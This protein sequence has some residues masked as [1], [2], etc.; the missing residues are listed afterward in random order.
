MTALRFVL[1][2]LRHYRRIHV[3]VALGVAVSTAVLAGAL[4]VGDS[5]RGSLRDLTL[6]RLG[7]IDSALVG[8][9]LFRAALAEDLAA[10]GEFQRHFSVAVPA[11]LTMGSAQ[12]GSGDELRRATSVSIVGV[13]PQFWSLG[14]G[15]PGQPFADGEVAITVELARELGVNV[16]Q[17]VLLR[18]PT[19]SAIPSDSPLGE[20]SNTSLSRQLRVAAVLPSVGLARFALSPSQHSP[21][22]AFVTIETLQDLLD[23]PGKANVILAATE[24]DQTASGEEA[25][26]ALQSVLRPRLEDY[27]LRVETVSTPTQY[28]Q[29]TSD[30]LVLPNEVVDAAQRAFRDGDLQPVVTYLANTIAI[31]DGA[32]LRKIPYSTITGVDSLPGIGPLLDEASNPIQLGE[33]EIVLNR[34]AADD[35]NAQIGDTITVTYYEPESSHGQLREHAPPPR[36]KL[37]SIVELKTPGGEPMPAADPKLTPEMPGV[38]DQASI[39]DWDLPFELVETIRRQDEDYWDEYRTTPKAF[40]PFETAKRL[41]A[42][43]WGTISLLRIATG[44]TASAAAIEERLLGELDPASLGLTFQ[45]V[46]AQGLAAASGTTPFD[47]LFLGFSFFLMASAVMLIALLFQLGVEQRAKELGTLAAVG[48]DRRRIGRLLGREGLL[49][50][51]LGATV[52]VAAGIVYAWLMIKGLTTWWVSAIGTPFLELHATPRSILLGWIIGVLVS[53]LAILWSIR[54]LARRSVNRLLAGVSSDLPVVASRSARRFSLW[55]VARGVLVLLA[56]GN[57]LFL[58]FGP[59]VRSETDA[60]LFFALGAVVLLLILGEIHQRLRTANASRLKQRG[61]SLNTL[62]ALNIARNAGRSTLT[63]GLVSAASFLILGISAFRLESTDKGTGGFELMATSDRPIHFDLNT[64]QGRLEL[65]FTDA[66]NDELEAWRVYSFRVAAGEDASCLN[67]YRPAQPRVLGVP[68]A[69]FEHTGFEFMDDRGGTDELD[70]E[71][72][73]PQSSPWGRLR[74]DLGGDDSGRSVVP[75][76][77]DAS[78]AAYSLHLKGLGSRLTIRDADNRPVT[79]E[80]VGLLKNSVLQGN[81][82]VSE[83]NFLRLFPDTGGY[84]FFLIDRRDAEIAGPLRGADTGERSSPAIDRVVRLLESAL[85]EDGFDVVDARQQ[86]A[87]FLAVQN[88]YLSTFQSLGALGLLLGTVGLAIVQLR[89]VLERRGELALMRAAGFRSGRLL[90]MVMLENVLLLLGGLIVGGIAAAIALVPQWLP[91][92]A[93]V[94]WHTLSVLLGAIA[95]IGLVAGWFATRSALRAPIVPA[96]RGD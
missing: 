40:V 86:L 75:V 38:T 59:P 61:M 28:V 7:R 79:L 63:I 81:L 53:W 64:P 21:K 49:V 88:T 15:G 95:I 56:L 51:A 84:R 78:T 24:N 27:A 12:A 17:Q 26:R 11:I 43:R 83:Q 65:G 39:N 5:V 69:M 50:A 72:S 87:Q 36:F 90:A 46:K 68:E 52:G 32:T 47:F 55:P 60:G 82:L 54:R 42:S 10:D 37:R 19:A 94:P 31:G 14:R 4:L 18:I 35:L 16:D 85:A 13:T 44:E 57:L 8:G 93:T 22:N 80:V 34:W 66:A 1:A 9:Q 41:W 91:R 20:K 77:L 33:D 29:I 92:E 45:P 3:A 25:Q 2:S 62:A 76:I 67:L 96:L 89:S 70:G 48:V 58:L 71:R 30:Q 74:D 73:R 6:Q 23:Q